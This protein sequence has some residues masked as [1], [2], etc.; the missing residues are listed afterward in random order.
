MP[1]KRWILG[2]CVSY[3]EDANVLESNGFTSKNATVTT[4]FSITKPDLSPKDIPKSLT[5]T[6]TK[7]S[8]Q[9]YA[10]N[11]YAAFS[12]S[13]PS[14]TFRS[15]MSTAKMRF[16]HG[17]SD[18]EIYIHQPEGFVSKENP[19]KVL[20]LNRALYGLKQSPR[21][22]YLCLCHVITSLGL[23]IME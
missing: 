21:I 1:Y 15:N 14:S 11:Q 7:P 20:R 17:A 10:L 18:V 22:W 13:P 23:E 9:L 19:Q 3:H 8:L 2:S 12:L 16:V 5:S 4:S 6:T